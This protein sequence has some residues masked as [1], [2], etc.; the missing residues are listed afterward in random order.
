[1]M[2]EMAWLHVTSANPKTVLWDMDG[3]YAALVDAA[4]GGDGGG[5]GQCLRH[6]DNSTFITAVTTIQYHEAGVLADVSKS[7]HTAIINTAAAFGATVTG[8]TTS[9]PTIRR[10]HQ[11]YRQQ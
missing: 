4:S 6:R 8:E 5:G 9:T 3:A 11:P 1:M 10:T 2:A 7:Y